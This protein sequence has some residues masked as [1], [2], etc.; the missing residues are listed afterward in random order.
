MTARTVAACR[1]CSVSTTRKTPIPV[2][3]QTLDRYAFP[4]NVTDSIKEKMRR[5][6]VESTAVADVRAQCRWDEA[7]PQL[8]RV[9][10]KKKR[11]KKGGGEGRCTV[12]L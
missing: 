7:K 6:E 11:K 3:S 10:K 4:A 12:G 2:G 5:S 9:K 8:N 1:P